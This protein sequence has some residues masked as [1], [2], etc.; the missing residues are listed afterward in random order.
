MADFNIAA[1]GENLRAEQSVP[2]TKMLKAHIIIMIKYSI[3]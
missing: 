2:I 1:Y 3:K